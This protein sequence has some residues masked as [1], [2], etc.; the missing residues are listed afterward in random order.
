MKIWPFGKRQLETRAEGF[1][2]AL[3]AALVSRADGTTIAA[4]SATSAL[5]ACSG[6]VGRSFAAALPVGRPALVMALTPS[7]LEMVGRSMIRLGECVFLIDTMGGMLHLIPA[8]MHDVSGGPRQDDWEYRLTL[9]GPTTTQ[10][11]DHIP[12]E[13]V[14]HFRYA[15]SPGA[16]WRGQGPISIAAIAGRLSAETMNVLADESSGPVGS[17]LGIPA[18]GEDATVEALKADIR[19]AQGRLALLESGDWGNTGGGMVDT[20]AKRFG[21]EPP[22][23]LVNLAD[24]ASREIYAACGLSAALFG[25]GDAASTREAW[26]LALFSV[27]S[28]MG[29]LVESELKAKLEDSVTLDWTPL[30]ASDL[31]GRARAFQSLAGGGMEIERAAMLSGLVV[32]E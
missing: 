5:E 13:S 4:P 1:T 26:R 22:Q 29:R 3:I 25:Q 14:L 20:K 2:D 10:T 11:Y 9:A 24:L 19:K 28:P 23:S 15:S 27:V 7:V 18:D 30:Q 21:A 32:A 17:L 8:E 16:P 6:L 31:S 12:S